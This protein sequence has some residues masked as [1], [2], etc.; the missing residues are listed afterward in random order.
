MEILP[1]RTIGVSSLNDKDNNDN[2]NND[3]DNRFTT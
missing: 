3:D 2:N 1:P